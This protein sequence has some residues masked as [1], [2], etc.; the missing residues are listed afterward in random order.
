[1]EDGLN[2]PDYKEKSTQTEMARY[3]LNFYNAFG[4]D[5]KWLFDI[6]PGIHVT[7]GNNHQKMNVVLVHDDKEYVEISRYRKIGQR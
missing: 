7:T 6:S 1:M 4:S 2:D 3:R 5:G